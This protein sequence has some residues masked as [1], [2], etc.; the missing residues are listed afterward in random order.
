MGYHEFRSLDQ[1]LLIYIVEHEYNYSVFI[2]EVVVMGKH[3]EQIVFFPFLV[4]P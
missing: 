1:G 4:I 3:I 2:W